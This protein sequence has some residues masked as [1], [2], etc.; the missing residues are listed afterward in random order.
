MARGCVYVVPLLVGGGTRIKIFEAMAA[1][2]AVVST[3]IGAEGLPVRHL[4]NILL[5]DEPE[6]FAN[7]IIELLSDPRRREHMGSAARKLVSENYSWQA[8]GRTLADAL[9][10]TA[11]QYSPPSAKK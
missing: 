7:R 3:T 6:D 8:V 11:A 4:E 9:E 1:G 10:G 5:A 2:K